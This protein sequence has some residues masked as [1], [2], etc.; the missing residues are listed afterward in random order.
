MLRRISVKPDKS[1]FDS[2]LPSNLKILRTC[3]A[4]ILKV[5]LDTIDQRKQYCDLRLSFLKI[6]QSAFKPNWSSLINSSYI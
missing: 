3:T 4:R 6:S 1:R 5:N 2:S